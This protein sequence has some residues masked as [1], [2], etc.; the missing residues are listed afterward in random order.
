[1]NLS[2]INLVHVKKNELKVYQKVWY[3]EFGNLAKITPAII[4][5]I[6]EKEYHIVILKFSLGLWLER[7]VPVDHLFYREQN[8]S[9]LIFSYRQ[10]ILNTYD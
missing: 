4:Y 10:E 8:I 3:A 5:D 7:W 2:D 9:E 6:P 1:M